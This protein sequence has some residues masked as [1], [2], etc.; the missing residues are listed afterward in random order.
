MM[1]S[2][3]NM[4][5]MGNSF[6]KVAR[7][8]AEFNHA[9]ARERVDGCFLMSCVHRQHN[10]VLLTSY[11]LG[12]SACHLLSCWLLLALILDPEDGGDMFLRNVG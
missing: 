10:T 8:W 7:K 5:V 9:V 3:G 1:E 2:L 11:R 4:V 6:L 12:G